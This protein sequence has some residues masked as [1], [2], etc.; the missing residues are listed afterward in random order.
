MKLKKSIDNI[1]KGK[2]HRHTGAARL[3]HWSYA[4]AVLASIASGLYIYNPSP[5]YGF[6]N[7]DS[8]RKT[9]FTSQFIIL[10]AYLARL[11]YSVRQKNYKEIIPSRKTIL[12]IPKFLKHEFFLTN[13]ESKYPKYNP[14]QKILFLGFTLLLPIQIITGLSI[15]NSNLWQKVTRMVGGL[16]RLRRLH[17]LSAL[18]VFILVSGHIYFALTHGLKTLKSIFTGYE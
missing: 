3:L 15:Y 1:I 17:F 14:G 2:K 6:K 4:P 7:M 11:L 18:G 10:F 8:A 13:K 5:S 16:N 12:D 9:H